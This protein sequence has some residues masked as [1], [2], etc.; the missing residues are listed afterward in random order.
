MSGNSLESVPLYHQSGTK[1]EICHWIAHI[2]LSR[3]IIVILLILF[4]ISLF[5]HYYLSK[6]IKNYIQINIFN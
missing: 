1:R 2:K 6:V 5:N 4:I 3:I